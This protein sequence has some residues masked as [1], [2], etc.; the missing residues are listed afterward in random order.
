MKHP[1][2]KS[3]RRERSCE[4]VQSTTETQY[5][6][7]RS[8]SG[9]IVVK[10]L[11]KSATRD[12]A[13]LNSMLVFLPSLVTCTCF[14]NVLSHVVTDQLARLAIAAFGRK[15]K[16][17]VQWASFLPLDELISSQGLRKLPRCDKQWW[18]PW[19]SSLNS[20]LFGCS[21]TLLRRLVFAL[22]FKLSANERLAIVVLWD[23]KS[24]RCI[25][26]ERVHMWSLK[27]LFVLDHVYEAGSAL[28]RRSS[29]L[30][31]FETFLA[32]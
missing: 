16:I 15:A 1:S 10:I 27:R 3:W 12:R 22:A 7:R 24:F 29:T 2:W 20:V 18:S 5:F 32:R 8:L 17:L 4:N 19:W 31:I 23:N 6:V 28:R 11:G 21:K 13:R 30:Y 26:G 25:E 14:S 9:S